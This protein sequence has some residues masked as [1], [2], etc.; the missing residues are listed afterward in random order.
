MTE[1]QSAPEVPLITLADARL[2]PELEGVAAAL[3]AEGFGLYVYRRDAR[4]ATSLTIER[5]GNVG[6]VS[7]DKITGYRVLFD[8]KPS[9]ETGSSLMVYGQEQDDPSD[10]ATVQALVLA[11]GLATQDTYCNFSTHG[12]ALPNYGWKAVEWAVSGMSHITADPFCQHCGKP[13][14]HGPGDN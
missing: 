7:Y 14:S 3:L 12:R 9:R 8:I 5:G 4:R 11:A 1:K 6:S 10:P 2:V 13:G